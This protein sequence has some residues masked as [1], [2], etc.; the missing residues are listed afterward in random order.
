[1]LQAQ[2]QGRAPLAEPQEASGDVDK[3]PKLTAREIA[4][5]HA[6]QGMLWIDPWVTRGERIGQVREM[7]T[8]GVRMQ[9]AEVARQ[10]QQ[11]LLTG[12]VNLREQIETTDDP[13]EKE[14]LSFFRD[15]TDEVIKRA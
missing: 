11:A 3:E 5:A 9:L 12:I 13:K 8:A 15:F 6:E 14:A 4:A 1:M 2:V 10:G 7:C